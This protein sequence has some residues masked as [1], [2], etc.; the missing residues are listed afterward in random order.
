M[1]KVAHFTLQFLFPNFSNAVGRY[2]S[3]LDIPHRIITFNEYNILSLSQ[4]SRVFGMLL[5]C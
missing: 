1:A 2:S 5:Q 3:E 4:A